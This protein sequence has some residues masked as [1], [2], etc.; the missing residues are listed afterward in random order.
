MEQEQKLHKNHPNK[1]FQISELQVVPAGGLDSVSGGMS[2]GAV[3][4]ASGSGVYPE[5]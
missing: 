2:P 4:G 5:K 3:D 1:P